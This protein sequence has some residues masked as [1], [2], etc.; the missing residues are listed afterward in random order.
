MDLNSQQCIN[1]GE[2]TPFFPYG[3]GTFQVYFLQL[4]KLDGPPVAY[5]A[6]FFVA[7]SNRSDVVVGQEYALYFSCKDQEKQ[8]ISASKLRSLCASVLGA[9]SG[10]PNFDG[11]A[12]LAAFLQA[13]EN[14]RNMGTYPVMISNQQKTSKKTGQP[15]TDN[16]FQIWKP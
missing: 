2:Q 16:R 15:Y 9:D 1:Y 4:S 14:L 11:N 6:K 7:S 3:D 10:D 13:G 5:L 8:A 12:A